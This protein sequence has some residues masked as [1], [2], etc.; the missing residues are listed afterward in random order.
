LYQIY[1]IKSHKYFNIGH[2]SNS[3]YMKLS[4]LFIWNLMCLETNL[5]TGILFPEKT[6]LKFF[7]PAFSYN[8]AP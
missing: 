7:T 5:T 1:K 2:N 6:E 3:K 8:W 4:G